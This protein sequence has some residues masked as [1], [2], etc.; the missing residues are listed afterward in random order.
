M[1]KKYYYYTPEYGYKKEDSF[2]VET[3]MGVIECIVEAIAW[4]FHNNHDG[5]E[6]TWPVIFHVWRNSGDLGVFEV[7]RATVPEFT[8]R[9][10]K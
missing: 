9:K 6:C 5:W 3:S 1:A 10:V 7:E 4:D 8:V 2:S